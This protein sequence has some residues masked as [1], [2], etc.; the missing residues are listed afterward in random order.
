MKFL[1]GWQLPDS[2]FN[3][4]GETLGRNRAIIAQLHLVQGL[5]TVIKSTGCRV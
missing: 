1:I 5:T 2:I 3:G 4:L